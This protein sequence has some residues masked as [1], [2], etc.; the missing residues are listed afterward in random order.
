MWQLTWKGIIL[1][2]L[3]TGRLLKDIARLTWQ[4]IDVENQEL[5]L[6]AAKTGRRMD[7]PLASPLMKKIAH[8]RMILYMVS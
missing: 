7:V 6:V 2:G 4:N 8:V 3:Y 1:S 5:R